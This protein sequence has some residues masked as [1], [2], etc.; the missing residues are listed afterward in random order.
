MRFLAAVFALFLCVLN[1]A[2]EENSRERVGIY[3]AK[4]VEL[5]KK[6]AIIDAIKR[7]NDE[8]PAEMDNEKWA[9]LA[10]T[11]EIVRAATQNEAAKLIRQFEADKGVKKVY[12]RNSRGVIIAGSAKA[13]LYN[14]AKHKHIAAALADF[15]PRSLPVKT[16]PLSGA[17]T[18]WIAVPVMENSKAIGVLHTEIILQASEARP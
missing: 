15:A 9:S 4:L 18:I 12:L 7:A 14:D 5:A 6:E 8:P 2:A 11:D 10:D 1:A 3:E 16:D 17:K 13:P